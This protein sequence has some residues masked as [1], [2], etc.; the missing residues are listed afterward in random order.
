MF[1]RLCSDVYNILTVC[2]HLRIHPDFRW[3][4]VRV[5]LYHCPGDFDFSTPEALTEALEVSVLSP[6]DVCYRITIVHTGLLG[7]LVYLHGA[8]G[9]IA[10]ATLL[11]VCMRTRQTLLRHMQRSEGA[12]SMSPPLEFSTKGQRSSRPGSV[13]GTPVLG[14]RQRAGRRS[15]AMASPVVFGC[16][17]DG[18]GL[19][20]ADSAGEPSASPSLAAVVVATDVMQQLEKVRAH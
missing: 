11:S 2:S 7:T 9:R 19:T 17:F 5:A 15:S 10:A 14:S 20:T 8:V 18:Q 6:G 1:A 4:Q 3:L 12:T 13:E 16:T